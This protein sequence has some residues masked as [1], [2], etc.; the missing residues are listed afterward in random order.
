MTEKD[1]VTFSI[2]ER[3]I[4]GE[5]YLADEFLSMALE[6]DM[7]IEEDS[8][9]VKVTGA[10]RLTGEFKP[11]LHEAGEPPSINYQK[12]SHRVKSVFAT[13]VG[14][15]CIEHRFPVD[16]TIPSYRINNMEELY[17]TIESFD[18]FLENSGEIDLT[19][20]IVLS[21]LSSTREPEYTK[22]VPS[23]SNVNPDAFYEEQ[24]EFPF[25]SNF[26]QQSSPSE[27]QNEG[28]EAIQEEEQ[29]HHYQNPSKEN[30]YEYESFRKPDV[31]FEDHHA[32]IPSIEI[33][34][35]HEEELSYRNAYEEDGDSS[36]Y[37]EEDDEN[38]Q[39]AYQENDEQ[40]RDEY[41]D[42]EEY[43]EES[44][45]YTEEEEA[46]AYD[47]EEDHEP[48]RPN[49]LYLTKMLSDETKP[50]S[51]V[52]MY[53]IQPGDSL[54]SVAERYQVAATSLIRMNRLESDQLSPGDILYIP[55]K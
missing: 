12:P 30:V 7:T 16:I 29:A 53:F 46:D 41:N 33:K 23:L 11:S 38:Y 14:T 48:E 15:Y 34:E 17:V 3:L 44:A 19:A 2:H 18:Y 49:A 13:D 24:P 55:V 21:G 25:L 1:P 43:T 36:Y 37:A 31:P 5:P 50:F 22:D 35:R 52:R 54:T 47:E 6:P 26:E 20:E 45:H 32:D 39:N 42:E 40:E 8:H 10:L 27:R 4:L 28:Q 51:K 9:Y